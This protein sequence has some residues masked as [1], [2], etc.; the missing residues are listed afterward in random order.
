[1]MHTID[2]E[3]RAKTEKFSKDIMIA[4]LEL[5]LAYGERFYNRQFITRKISN[6]KLLDRLKE[7]LSRYFAGDLPAKGLPTVAWIA[8]SLNTV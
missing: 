4:Q 7:L 6:H 2:Q 8:S 3:H 1:M 5:L